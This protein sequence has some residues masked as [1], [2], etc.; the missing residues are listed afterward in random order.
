MGLTAAEIDSLFRDFP[1]LMRNV[2][3]EPL[4]TDPSFGEVIPW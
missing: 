3:I 4:E 1:V 2:S